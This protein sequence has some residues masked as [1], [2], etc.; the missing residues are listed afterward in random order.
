MELLAQITIFGI[1]ILVILGGIS[2][3][4]DDSRDAKDKRDARKAKKF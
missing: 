1:L 2:K 4:L 3:C